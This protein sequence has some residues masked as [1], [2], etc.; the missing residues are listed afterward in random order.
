MLEG[1]IINSGKAS[2]A[3]SSLAVYKKV[4]EGENTNKII[5]II[6]IKKRS[7]GRSGQASAEEKLGDRH[8]IE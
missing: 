8:E 6:M 3:V 5:I 7:E 1:L 2:L 4:H